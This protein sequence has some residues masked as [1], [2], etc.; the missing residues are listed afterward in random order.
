MRALGLM[1]F[2]LLVCSELYA[3]PPLPPR[4]IEAP[5]P[6]PP[7][8]ITT[9]ATPEQ[10]LIFGSF[11]RG[12]TGGTVIIFSDGSRSVT[13]DIIQSNSGVPFSPAIYEIEANLGTVVTILNGSD[14][15]LNGSNGGTVSLHIGG[16][17]TG[18]PFI[19]SAT[20]PARTTIRIGGTL[21]VGGPLTS[22]SGAYSGVFYV[23]F[24][25]Q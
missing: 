17:S 14:V 16:S 12:N 20:T 15:T 6:Q 19:T 10:G 18:S 13:G 22:P 8:P 9:Y 5:P 21:T 2:L 24:I 11:F 23:T 4:P 3:Q 25:Q 7:R 1:G